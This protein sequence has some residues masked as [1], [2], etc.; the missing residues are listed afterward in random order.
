MKPYCDE[1][2]RP[3]EGVTVEEGWQVWCINCYLAGELDN[4]P[5]VERETIRTAA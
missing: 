1:C 3:C 2:G 4:L 5:V